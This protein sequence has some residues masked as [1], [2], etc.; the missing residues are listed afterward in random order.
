MTAPPLARRATAYLQ[1]T[2]ACSGALRVTPAV[3]ARA[4]LLRG[5]PVWRHDHAGHLLHAQPAAAAA[6]AAAAKVAALARLE[7]RQRARL[8]EVG[9]GGI[10]RGPASQAA[11]LGAVGGGGAL[12]P[13]R[14]QELLPVRVTSITTDKYNM[15]LVFVSTQDSKKHTERLTGLNC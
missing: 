12:A 9:L 11:A 5:Q 7:L 10:R 3:R 2:C 8:R 1:T 6:L 15:T 4:E 14:R 13:A